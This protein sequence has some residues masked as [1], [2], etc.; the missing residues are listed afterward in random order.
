MA[1][2]KPVGS[3]AERTANSFQWIFG[4]DIQNL[5][6]ERTLHDLHW[7]TADRMLKWTR[8]PSCT[9]CFCL[10]TGIFGVR[11]WQTIFN[12]SHRMLHSLSW[13]LFLEP[14]NIFYLSLQCLSAEQRPRKFYLFKNCQPTPHFDGVKNVEPTQAL[15]LMEKDY[16]VRNIATINLR[17]V[18]FQDVD[19]ISVNP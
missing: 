3:S 6:Q 5:P 17:F 16:D 9:K 12:I 19:T 14:C 2:T 1:A 18:Q 11:S 13:L 10:Q 4:Y 8:F 7:V 15:E